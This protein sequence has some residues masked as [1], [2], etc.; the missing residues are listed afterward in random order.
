M[1]PTYIRVLKYLEDLILSGKLSAGDKIPSEN[2]LARMFSTTRVTVRK[3]LDELEKNGIISKVPGVGTF[4]TEINAV[5]HK[6]VGVVINSKQI[7]YG[8]VKFLSSVGVKIFAFEQGKNVSEEEQILNQLISTDIDGLLMEPTQDS[9]NNHF[10]RSLAQSNFP[11]VFVDRSI[12]MPTKIP[13]VLTNNYI[14]GKVLGEHMLRAHNVT[15]ALFV[16]SEDMSISSV[17][18]RFSGISKGLKRKPEVMIIDRI[19]GDFGRLP[20]LVKEKDI[21]CIFFCNDMLA[22]RGAFHLIKSGISI[23]D[24]VSIVGFDDEFV[25][26]MVEPKLTT[27]KQDLVKM[28][29][30]A[31]SMMISVLKGEKISNDILINAELI[32]RESCGC[33]HHE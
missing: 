7:M 3:A 31:A 9:I 25:A 18:E 26:K 23:P 21:D 33:T 10:L 15:R 24:D 30:T 16:T 29:E 32:V 11:I 5:A 28:G 12:P 20:N 17:S 6:R 2:E 14:G 19:D 27:V 4:V 8:A 22:V 13:S 1:V